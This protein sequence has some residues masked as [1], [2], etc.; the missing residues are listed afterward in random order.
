MDLERIVGELGVTVRAGRLPEG[1]WGSYNHITHEITMRP[2]LGGLQRRSTLAH[3][4]GHAYYRHECSTPQTERQASVW[5]ARR[6]IRASEFIDACRQDDTAHG[7]AHILGV[8]PRDVK[9]YVTTL[10]PAE[11]LLIRQIIT[12]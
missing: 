2:R 6:L 8:L 1:W 9:N 11:T 5:A 4:L 12:N 7:I 3:E 10:T